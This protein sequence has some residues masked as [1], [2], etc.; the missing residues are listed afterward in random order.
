MLRRHSSR[1][2]YANFLSKLAACHVLFYRWKFQ[3]ANHINCAHRI[4]ICA[5]TLCC[6]SFSHSHSVPISAGTYTPV[7]KR[8][9]NSK[10]S[11][12]VA[13]CL[14]QGQDNS[15][16]QKLAVSIFCSHLP[17]PQHNPGRCPPRSRFN[18]DNNS[19]IAVKTWPAIVL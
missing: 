13:F 8:P 2:H 9:E 18:G 5:F 14:T 10:M 11:I 4:Y 3:N 1:T 16:Q 15:L 7:M 12:A 19:A 6:C 17:C